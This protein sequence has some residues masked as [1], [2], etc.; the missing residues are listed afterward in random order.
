V[1]APGGSGVGSS[2]TEG[3]VP[4]VCVGNL[5]FFVGTLF[6]TLFFEEKVRTTAEYS[7]GRE[8]RGLTGFGP[9]A[10]LELD[11]FTGSLCE[12]CAGIEIG[13]LSMSKQCMPTF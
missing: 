13:M 10:A 5:I 6:V 2:M 12:V 11:M 3:F 8:R 9:A 4:K 7:K 1:G